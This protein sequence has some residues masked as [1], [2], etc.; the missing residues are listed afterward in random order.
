MKKEHYLFIIFLVI[1]VS[2]VI[3]RLTSF[4][5]KKI[6]EKPVINNN[7]SEASTSPISVDAATNTTATPTPVN[8]ATL[9]VFEVQLLNPIPSQII[10]SPLEVEGRA[11]GGWFFE[12]TLPIKLISENGDLITQGYGQAQSDW[13][14]SD[15]VD[16]KSTLE[17]TTTSTSGY[18]IISKDNPSGLPENDNSVA[19]PVLFSN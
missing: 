12:A 14:T 15:F 2:A 10:S 16:F 17:F 18:L 19:F 1:V 4:G 8:D 7:V 3:L 6:I 13:M 9:V 5:N 11:L